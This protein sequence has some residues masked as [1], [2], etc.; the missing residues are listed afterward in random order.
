MSA[1]APL[2]SVSPLSPSPT[3]PG[4]VGS[5]LPAGP[6]ER[7]S[8]LA[9]IGGLAAGVLLAGARTAQAGPLNPPGGPVTST[10]KTL[11]EV[12]PRVAINATNTPGDAEY[13]FKI[14]QPGSYYLTGDIIGVAGKNGI[15]IA[16]SHVTLD[17][18]GFSVRGN[19]PFQDGI[20]AVAGGLRNIQ[21]YN[22]SAVG[23][24]RYGVDVGSVI[25]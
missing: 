16:A 12:E 11:T 20:A 8:L 24:G 9:G 1:E 25:V 19:G 21:I 5:S 18:N 10:G 2:P 6:S 7:R 3:Q 13:S 23:W 17:L 22:G 4:S 14:T 15:N